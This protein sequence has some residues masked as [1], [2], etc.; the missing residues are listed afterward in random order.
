MSRNCSPSHAGHFG[1][2]IMAGGAAIIHA[3]RLARYKGI[4]QRPGTQRLAQRSRRKGE[5][6]ASLQVG[7]RK[8]VPD[9]ILFSTGLEI[10]EEGYGFGFGG[11]GVTC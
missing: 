1:T 4:P 7:G 11:G 5:G 6:P 9:L 8:P 3:E 10:L 2:A